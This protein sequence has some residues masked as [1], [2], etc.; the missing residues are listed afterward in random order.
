LVELISL[1][2]ALTSWLRRGMNSV[3]SISIDRGVQCVI[4]H[5][6]L[7]LD[8]ETIV[9]KKLEGELGMKSIVCI[10]CSIHAE[11]CLDVSFLD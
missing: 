6:Q 3:T 5:Y 7:I 4:D 11:C 8:R 1:G 9:H 2:I 10:H